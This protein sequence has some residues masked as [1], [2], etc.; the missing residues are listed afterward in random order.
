MSDIEKLQEEAQ[1]LTDSGNTFEAEEKYR[2]ALGGLKTLLSPTHNTTKALAYRVAEFYAQNGRMSDADAVLNWMGQKHIERW[3]IEDEKTISHVVYAAD[4]L[5]RWSRPEDAVTLIYGA[6]EIYEK[7]VGCAKACELIDL[8]DRTDSR[9]HQ[10][11]LNDSVRLQN[12]FDYGN[13]TQTEE[14]RQIQ[15]QLCLAKAYTKAEDKI[16][17]SLLTGLITQC[18]NRSKTLTVQAF[19]ARYSLLDYYSRVNR[20]DKLDVALA[21]AQV[22]VRSAFASQGERS[23]SLLRSTSNIAYSHV[24]AGLLEVA[25][26]LLIEIV[27]VAEE[28]FGANGRNTISI[29]IDFGTFYEMA[30]RWADARPYF[31]HALAASMKAT[32]R[33]SAQTKNLEAALENEHYVGCAELQPHQFNTT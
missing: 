24:K 30:Q 28:T 18:S 12:R 27:S 7:I 5:C 10:L 21:E 11:T 33:H 19:D 6:M 29:L 23:L 20:R 16:A 22:A 13:S 25:E 17:E 15:Y 2:S 26:D 8:F 4:M 14:E 9:Q 32:G 1:D 3:G 31:E